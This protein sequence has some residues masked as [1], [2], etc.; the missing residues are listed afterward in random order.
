MD[1]L[2]HL[3]WRYRAIVQERG[4]HPFG[5]EILFTRLE[6]LRIATQRQPDMDEG[7]PESVRV[8]VRQPRGLEGALED[9]ADGLGLAPVP[10]GQARATK[11]LR[12]AHFHQN[13]R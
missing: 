4:R 13:R 10:A 3:L 12:L 7:V 2:R 8:E 1:D 6:L 9:R 5:A 11:S